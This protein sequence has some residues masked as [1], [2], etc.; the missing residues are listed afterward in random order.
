M[1]SVQQVCVHARCGGCPLLALTTAEQLVRKRGHLE[2]AVARHGELAGLA[3]PQ[4]TAAEPS[5]GYRTRAKLVVSAAGEIGLYARGGHEIVDIPQC[6]VLSPKLLAVVAALRVQLTHVGGVVSGIDVREVRGVDA[7]GVLITLLG[8]ARDEAK[9]LALAERMAQ[10]PDV[11]GVA[12]GKREARSAQLLGEA[13]ARVF[14]VD[15]ARDTIAP[16][17]PYHYATYGAFVQAHRGQALAVAE[18]LRS[19]LTRALGAIT[20]VRVLELYAGSGALGLW[21]AKHGAQAVLVERYDPALAL[22]TRAAQEQQIAG[23]ALRAGDAEAVLLDLVHQKQ[24]FDAI[25]VNPPRRGLSPLVRA[26]IA[27]LSPRALLY[28]SCNPETLAR[29]LADFA[30]RGL[31]VSSLAPFDMMPQSD[32]VEC[33][34]CLQ[35]AAPA[36][37]RVLY[38]DHALIAVDKPAHLPTIPEAEHKSSLL[39]RLQEQL[40]V[41]PLFAVHR[42]DA[43]TS[44]V[45]LFAKQSSDVAQLSAALAAGQK[46]YTALVR[47]I[48][49]DKG[50]IKKPLRDGKTVREATT[51]Y[52]RKKVI[53]GH[54][55]LRVRPEHGRKHQVRRHLAELDHPVLGDAR[56]GAEPSNRHFEHKHGLDRT[57]LHLSRIELQLPQ[58]AEPLV[59]EAA[60]PGDLSSVLASLTPD[61]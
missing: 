1:S 33:V 35:P 2:L 49:H 45:C 26:R 12:L 53:A 19:E 4:L 27:E 10:L 16:E 37:L 38:Q 30:R 23:L 31:A 44:G 9:L 36:P 7:S 60:L 48:T 46:H 15:V 5:F 29:D 21:L 59:L 25:L 41:S 42:L 54:S 6:L 22:L 43:G 28:V 39:E 50:I 14:G 11:L 8:E 32:D 58:R 3:V 57:F 34:V 56:Y 61:P 52:T 17:G 18:Q 24:R 13:P 51:R 40:G 55:L 20:G 47:G